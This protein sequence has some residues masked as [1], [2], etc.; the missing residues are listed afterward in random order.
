M[1]QMESA[2]LRALACGPKTTA[3]LWAALGMR[4]RQSHR[5]IAVVCERLRARGDVGRARAGQRGVF[6][7][8][9]LAPEVRARDRAA[10]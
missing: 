3:E 4:T 2:V 1:S 10:A 6:M 5:V 9:S 8:E 7:W